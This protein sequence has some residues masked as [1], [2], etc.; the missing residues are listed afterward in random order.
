MTPRTHRLLAGAG[1]LAALV[2]A[3][4]LALWPK[5]PDVEQSTGEVQKQVWIKVQVS[6]ITKRWLYYRSDTSPNGPWKLIGERPAG[7]KL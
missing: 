3:G 5:T 2:T 6:P 1:I 4:V 7:G